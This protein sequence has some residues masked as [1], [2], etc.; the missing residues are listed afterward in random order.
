MILR[1]FNGKAG[2][3]K[4]PRESIHDR[5]PRETER[6]YSEYRGSDFTGVVS[7]SW[8]R[9]W[10]ASLLSQTSSN[11]WAASPAAWPSN[12]SMSPKGGAMINVASAIPR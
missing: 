12:A 11:A 2:R 1:R 10:S 8:S 9:L 4:A 5:M 6:M 3:E 7:R